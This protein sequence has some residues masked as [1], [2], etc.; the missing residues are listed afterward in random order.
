MPNGPLV[1]GNF[2]PTTDIYDV[3]DIETI[4]DISPEF[5]EALVRLYL[6]LN[7]MLLVINEKDIGTY[8]NT[9]PFVNGQTWFPN[10]NLA[11]LAASAVTTQNKRQVYRTVIDFGALPNATT[12]SAP[13]YIIC[14][15]GTSFTRIYATA[16]DTTGFTYLP[17]PYASPTAA[18]NIE[19]NVDGTNVN[20]ITG[21]NRSN[22]N[23]CYVILEYL[24][25]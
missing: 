11:T 25:L 3:A 24:L 12:K 23:I 5:R 17:I 7:R 10:P 9:S 22:Y 6:N 15:A 4:Q 13:H 19:I 14:N 1:Q 2:L 16:S 21:S 8:D 18:N 20:I